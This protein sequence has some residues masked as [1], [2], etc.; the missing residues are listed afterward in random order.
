LLVADNHRQWDLV[1]N[2]N[3]S[4]YKRTHLAAGVANRVHISYAIDNIAARGHSSTGC[5]ALA[6]GFC[7]NQQ[8]GGTCR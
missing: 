4:A 1:V 2:A 5:A 3:S 8:E 6:G 7:V